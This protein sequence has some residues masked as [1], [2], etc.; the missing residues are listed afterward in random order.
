MNFTTTL[1][2]V[3][4]MFMYMLFGFLMR[5]FNVV[6]SPHLKTVSSIMIYVCAPALTINSFQNIKYSVENIK[7]MFIFFG[8]V[9]FLQ[10]VA[11][12][13]PFLILRKKYEEAKYRLLTVGSILGN[14]GFFGIPLISALY[15]EQKIVQAYAC[16]YKVAMNFIIFTFGI[17]ALTMDKKFISAFKAFI[18]PPIL[19]FV[20]ALIIYFTKWHFPE[21]LGN[22]VE[23]LGKMSTPLCMIVVGVRLASL[24]SILGLFTKPFVYITIALKLV[25]Y[26]LFTFVCVYFLPFLDGPFIGSVLILS[27][28]PNPPLLVALAEVHNAEQALACNLVILSHIACIITLPLISM[29]MEI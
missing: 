29:L 13:I 16:M 6:E 22:A 15:P 11:L 24:E 8:I 28:A 19:G 2:N 10:L 23:L 9:L 26:P 18:N 3:L 7:N 12:V 21:I 27:G 5:K 20:V 1:Y 4:I 17:Y 14:V 25:I